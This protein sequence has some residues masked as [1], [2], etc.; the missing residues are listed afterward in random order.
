[1]NMHRLR[2]SFWIH[3]MEVLGD[4]GQIEARISPFGD[5]VNLD[6]R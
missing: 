3:Q 6:A 5:N 2:K 4:V 1:M